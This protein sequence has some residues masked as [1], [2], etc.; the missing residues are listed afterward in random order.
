MSLKYEDVKGA[1]DTLARDSKV[2]ETALQ[3]VGYPAERT[4]SRDSFSLARIIVGQQLSTKAAA[5]INKRLAD[6]LG[7]ALYSKIPDLSDDELRAV[8]LSRP[9]IRYLRALTNA[10][11]TGA[12]PFDRFDSMSDDQVVECLTA[13]PG[14]GRWSA[15]MYLI[16]NLQR[17][18][19]WPTGDLAV[20]VGVS[21]MLGASERLTET[22]LEKVGDAWRP[23]RSAVA[24]LAWHFYS[25]APDI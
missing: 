15:H 1:L 21:R 25:N 24:L 20:R 3:L 19:V 17:P 4:G 10:V 2:I 12:L 11:L 7:D 22:E 5:S 13:L 6:L 9:K 18:D 8:G 23:H 14:F 16:F